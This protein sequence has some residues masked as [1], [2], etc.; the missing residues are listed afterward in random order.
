MTTNNVTRFLDLKRI[1][2]K[3]F[4]L[5]AEKL[6]AL[7]TARLIGVEPGQVFKSIVVLRPKPGKHILAIVPGNSEVNLKLLASATGDKKLQLSTQAEAEKLTGLQ[8]GG[9]SPLALINRGFQIWLDSSAC[10]FTE[11]HISGGQ[12][13]LNI[14]LSVDDLVLLTSACVASVS[15]PVP[16]E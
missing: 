5:P 1:N 14:R 4:E 3:A 13:G 2:Y 15:S 12:R 6:G 9:I 16:V 8:T 10:S 7:E 11:I